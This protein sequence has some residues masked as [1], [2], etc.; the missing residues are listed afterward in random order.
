MPVKDEILVPAIKDR[1]FSGDALPSEDGRW[2]LGGLLKRWKGIFAKNVYAD[3]YGIIRSG[4]TTSGSI[5]VGYGYES[6][7]SDLT[8]GTSAAS[9]LSVTVTMP[10]MTT[11]R[12]HAIC[13]FACSA[14]TASQIASGQIYINSS[15]QS[16]VPHTFRNSG[17]WFSVYPILHYSSGA[18]GDVTVYLRGWKSSSSNTVR[19]EADYSRL[20]WDIVG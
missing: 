19:M 8:L 7:S 11:L 16:T 9:I 2:S 3:K 17:D 14:F 13:S 1:S 4:E 6:P 15:N 18:G 5:I 20:E 12:A 10:P